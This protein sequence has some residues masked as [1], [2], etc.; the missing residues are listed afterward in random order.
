MDQEA[1]R[2]IWEELCFHLSDNINPNINENIFE[3]KVLF[4]LEKLKWSQRR[5]EIK[6]KPSLQIGRQNTIT[7]DIV[8]HTTNNRAAIV[9]EIKRPAEDLSRAGSVGQLKS[10]MR[11][12]KSD[13]GLLVGR[14]IHVYYDGSLNPDASPLLLSKIRF[15]TDS[16]EGINFVS[17]F[18][19]DGFVAGEYESFLKA[20]IDRLDR[21]RRINA[22][23][24]QLLSE[25]TRQKML[26]LLQHEFNGVESRILMEALKGLTIKISH[27]QYYENTEK[28]LLDVVTPERDHQTV[29][30]CKNISSGKYFIY[31][32]R[33]INNKLH[34]INPDGSHIITDESHFSTKAPLFDQPKEESIEYLLSRQLITEAQLNKYMESQEVPDDADDADSLVD[35]TPRRNRIIRPRPT[36]RADVTRTRRARHPFGCT[37]EGRHF[38]HGSEA[39]DYLVELGK[40]PQRDLPTCSTNWHQWLNDHQR[41]Y[42]FNY[43]RD[44]V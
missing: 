8:I 5:G 26:I 33:T 41:Q 27:E 37:V 6:V 17:L 35:Q 34:L 16:E 14:E 29:T 9:L 22:V 15:R 39:K 28:E 11:Q 32:E 20:Y 40:I 2:E 30:I 38:G 13:F 3:Q 44:E 1:L 42:R 31:L 18:N 19:R 43:Q 24:D 7:P 25:E 10:Y 23:R 36:G 4:T 21:E 12:T